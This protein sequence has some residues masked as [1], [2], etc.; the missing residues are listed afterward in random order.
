MR[1][2]LFP[3]GAGRF[4]SRGVPVPIIVKGVL[5]G[6]GIVAGICAIAALVYIVWCRACGWH[7]GYSGDRAR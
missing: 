2:A 4:Y 3:K 1:P 6:L 7:L 5:I